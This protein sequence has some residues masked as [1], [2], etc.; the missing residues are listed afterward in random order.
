M[1][2]EGFREIAMFDRSVKTPPRQHAYASEQ[3][4]LNNQSSRGTSLLVRHR[5]ARN[6]FAGKFPRG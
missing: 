4:K 2:Q 3:S 5:L 1:H 6:F